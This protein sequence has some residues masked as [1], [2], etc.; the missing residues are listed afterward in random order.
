MLLR[1]ECCNANERIFTAVSITFSISLNH[2]TTTVKI[3]SILQHK[4]NVCT[5]CTANKPNYLSFSAILHDL[6]TKCDEELSSDDDDL[7]QPL[8]TNGQYM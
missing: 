5:F 7:G 2:P 1:N 4:C 8:P 6:W 3:S